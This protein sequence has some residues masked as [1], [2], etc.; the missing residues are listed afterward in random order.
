MKLLSETLVS[1][2]LFGSTFI[3]SEVWIGSLSEEKSK[4]EWEINVFD[5]AVT[6][7][8]RWFGSLKTFI[9]D[10]LPDTIFWDVKANTIHS[11]FNWKIASSCRK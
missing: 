4:F 2:I 11:Y 7:H 6:W 1:T 8:G 9:R 10:V 5:F 3:K